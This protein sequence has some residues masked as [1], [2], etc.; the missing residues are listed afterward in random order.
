MK[1]AHPWLWTAILVSLLLAPAGH[2]DS[3]TQSAPGARPKLV[4]LLAVDQM[5]ADYHDWYGARWTGGLRRL[6]DE[7][8]WFRNA[9]FPYLNTVTCAGHAT[10]STG[11]YPRTHGMILNYW[12]D[13]GRQKLIE[14]TDDPDASTLAYTSAIVRGG[15]SPKSLVA[16]TLADEMQAQLSPR[17]RVASFSVKARSA[18]TMGGRKPDVVL[19]WTPSTW[20][21]STVFGTEKIPW[22]VKTLQDN[23]ITAAIEAGW[24]KLLADGDY[25]FADDAIGEK[26]P[27]GWSK[28]FP[29]RIKSSSS[30]GSWASTPFVDE[31]LG[32]LGRAAVRQMKLGQTAG[33][34][35]LAI[36]FSM[37][38]HVGHSFGPRSHEVQDTLARLDRTIGDLLKTLD[39]EVGRDK[40]VLALSADHGVAFIPEQAKAD[41]KDAGR[42]SSAE[43]LKRA[44]QAIA[45]EIGEGTHALEVQGNDVYLA[46][47]VY[48]RLSAKRGAMKRVLAGIR[49]IPGVAE[50]MDSAEV[51][52]VRKAKGALRKA[53]ALSYFPGRS[54]EI[55]I[56]PKPHWIVSSMGTTHGSSH[57]YDQ[58]VPVVFYGKGIKPGKYSREISP[59]DVAPTLARLVGVHMAKAEGKPVA[60]IAALA[61]L[62]GAS[63]PTQPRRPPKR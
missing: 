7:G 5:R 2:A 50:A 60:E 36:S 56:S 51:K 16:P 15:D 23:P 24:T 61:G 22:V 44:S 38:D 10:L 40:Y 42:I 28:S 58:L 34:D 3:G 63:T 19:W 11:S 43:F 21:S 41:G 12:Y 29:H 45:S 9:R 17:P 57:D 27:S 25:S 47:G 14:C 30:T 8:A 54:G 53:A 13:R 31:Y 52:D 18:I 26:P 39:E 37:T 20:A 59:A 62:A 33:T 32:V 46:P 1:R 55:L 49:T 6:F 4:V 35:Y 48:E